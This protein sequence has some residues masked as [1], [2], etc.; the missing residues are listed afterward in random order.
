MQLWQLGFFALYLSAGVASAHFSADPVSHTDRGRET[1]VAQ[2]TPNRVP[3]SPDVPYVPT[4][5]EVV[6]EMLKIARVT[7]NDVLY[8]LGS[9]DGRIAI[10]AAREYGTR[11]VGIEINPQLIQQSRE[12]AQ[13][14][15]VSDLVQFLQQDLFQTDLRD[16]TVITLYLLP[17]LNQKLRPQLLALKPGTRVVSHAFDMGEWKPDQVA[18]VRRPK[19]V[20]RLVYYWIIPAN[21]Q[22]TWQANVST[23]KN[24]QQ[25]YTIQLSQQFQQVNVTINSNGW[26]ANIAGIKLLGNQLR[27]NG[28][29]NIQGQPASIQFTGRVDGDT[30][31]GTA[32]IQGGFYAGRY[33]LVARLGHQ[34]SNHFH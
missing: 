6:A 12:N 19:S 22:G 32:N 11:G 1:T 28:V 13:K 31:K 4:P 8:D 26:D 18:L 17:E 34:S 24:A 16:A 33:N 2:A 5:N 25:R 30:L 29:Q 14:A 7:G 23:P 9:G 27:W 3:V 10:A 15:G 20:P 21:V